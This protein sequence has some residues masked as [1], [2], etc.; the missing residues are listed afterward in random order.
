M[1]CV[2]VLGNTEKCRTIY[3]FST[4]REAANISVDVFLFILCAF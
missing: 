3:N 1:L 2:D 4:K